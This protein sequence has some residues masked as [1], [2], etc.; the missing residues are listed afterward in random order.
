MNRVFQ[1]ESKSIRTW[2]DIIS[3]PDAL[4]F[5]GLIGGLDR[6]QTA[7]T[8]REKGETVPL[9]RI[10]GFEH[11]VI[12][13][14]FDNPFVRKFG[15][16]LRTAQLALRTPSS[17]VSLSFRN[18]MCILASRF[19]NIPAI[20]F[21]DNDITAHKD[22]LYFEEL[23]NRLE[24][25]AS[26]TIVPSAF[27]TET[28]TKWEA[29]PNTIHTFDGYKEDIY[30]ATFEP[31]PNYTEN[32]PFEEYIVIRPEA[33][34]A[35]YVEADTI[36]PN[37]LANVVERGL[38]VV[39]LPRGRGDET[40]AR[41]Y[42]QERVYTPERALHGLQLA[43]HSRCVLTGSGTMAREAACMGKPAVS[44]FPSP[45]LSVDRELVSNGRLYHSRD[46]D[47][48]VDYLLGLD[49][50]DTEPDCRHASCVRAEAIELINE[51]I[52]TVTRCD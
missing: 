19:K 48:I 50:A 4:F 31:D 47:A 29:D 18:A 6:K 46:P 49:A 27:A 28:L 37:L 52:E 16:P 34:T 1:S 22:G 25:T 20:H 30:V 35:A 10:A 44:F 45:L 2:I 32:L 26:H 11:D 40:Y 33:L 14:D 15:I 17:G 7:V 51:L 21:T 24:A 42:P 8:V 38:N 13:R 3:P 36:V 23:Y 41:R 43:W 9:T 5:G 39:Y 12:G